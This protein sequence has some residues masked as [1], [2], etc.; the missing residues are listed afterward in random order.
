VRNDDGCFET[1][2]IHTI[3]IN[4]SK[5]NTLAKYT[6]GQDKIRLYFEI[7]TVL[8]MSLLQVG[9]SIFLP[10]KNVIISCQHFKGNKVFNI[11]SQ[12]CQLNGEDDYKTDVIQFF[13]VAF[14]SCLPANA[15]TLSQISCEILKYFET[16]CFVQPFIY[17]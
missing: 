10:P 4:F 3:G 13:W 12:I 14:N 6:V 1:T 15:D 2:S 9:I 16:F 11:Q 17:T 5:P 8:N 7:R